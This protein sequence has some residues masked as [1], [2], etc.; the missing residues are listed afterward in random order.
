MLEPVVD[1]TPAELAADEWEPERAILD[2][3]RELSVLGQSLYKVQV[4]LAGK[5]A[6]PVLDAA[7]RALGAA[8]TGPWVVLSQGVAADDYLDAVRSAC[9]A[10]ASG[11]LAGRAIWAD[12]VGR[13]DLAQALTE[14]AVPRLQRLSA[15]V[16]ATATPWPERT[17]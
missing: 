11:F 2:A 3:A 6:G 12:L 13:P 10:G 8:I 9:G 5:E 14:V 16:D 4:P 17:A 7:C 15:V 1:A